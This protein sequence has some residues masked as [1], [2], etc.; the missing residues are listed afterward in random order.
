MVHGLDKYIYENFE[1]AFSKT[2]EKQWCTTVNC[3]IFFAVLNTVSI[4]DT[5]GGHSPVKPA[6]GGLSVGSGPVLRPESELE[7]SNHSTQW[8]APWPGCSCS[9]VCQFILRAMMLFLYN[10]LV[11]C[12][13]CA[14]TFYFS[15]SISSC[16]RIGTRCLKKW[17]VCW[18]SHGH[19]VT[20]PLLM[21]GG[22]DTNGIKSKLVILC[23][24]DLWI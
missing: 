13:V 6:L 14:S 17:D 21:F 8:V 9:S 20:Y 4:L 2:K 15:S 22:E 7:T 23:G 16:V 12:M 5:V 19:N 10:S 11:V 18:N 24:E 1:Y 3:G